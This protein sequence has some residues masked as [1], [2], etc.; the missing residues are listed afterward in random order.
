M[1]VDIQPF[2]RKTFNSQKKIHHGYFE[3]FVVA[4]DTKNCLCLYPKS[5]RNNESIIM[6]VGS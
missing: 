1:S 6:I 2:P 3:N 5:K 4:V